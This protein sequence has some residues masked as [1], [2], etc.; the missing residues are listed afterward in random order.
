MDESRAVVLRTTPEVSPALDISTPI[1]ICTEIDPF[2]NFSDIDRSLLDHFVHSTSNIIACHTIVQENICQVI[3]PAALENPTLFYATMALSAIHQK[4]QSGLDS[5]AVRRDPLV[6]HLL[7]NSLKRLQAELIQQDAKKSSVLLATIRTLFLCEVHSGGDRPG[8]WRAHFE[9][10]KALMHKIESWKGYSAKERDSTAYFL[11]RWYNMTESFVALTS[12]SLATGQLA[13]F[14]PRTLN[15]DG[16]NEIYLD[17]Y[18]GF[19][20]DL[21]SLFCEIGAC[22]WERRK[23][24]SLDHQPTILYDT[25]LDEESIYLEQSIWDRIEFNK[26]SPPRFRPGLE[27]KLSVRQKEDFLLCNEA[28]HHMALIYIHRQISGLPAFATAV[29]ESVKRILE[30]IEG[31]TATAGLTPLVVLTTPLFAAGCEALGHDRERVRGILLNMFQ[32]L[33]IPN[34]Y[35]SLEVLESFWSNDCDVQDWDSF[36]KA[37]HWDFLP[38]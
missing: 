19:T 6:I 30:C 11:K 10:A 36:M 12:D 31:I 29:Q 5:A 17:E 3:V 38:Y 26:I 32:L 7:G 16:D 27:E 37:Q 15:G 18:A 34:V 28:W 1:S 4:S 21:S 25:D 14:E 22:A 35:R 23:A 2:C 24:R 33:R 9:G 20:T 8:T 13:R